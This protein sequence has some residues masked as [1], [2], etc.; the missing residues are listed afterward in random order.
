MRPLL[1]L[2]GFVLMLPDTSAQAAAAA[3]AAGSS[4]GLIQLSIEQLGQIE[5]TSVSRREESLSEAPA[6]IY[7]IT[8]QQI[9]LSGVTSIPEALRL[10]PGVEVARNGSHSW[11]ISLRGFNSDL[12]NK[13]LVL[14]D[15]RT[16][17]SPLFA[18]V[19]WDVQ[20]MLL[21]DIERIEVIA[22]PGGTL[23]GSNA[24]NGVINIITRSAWDTRG[25]FFGSAPE[26]RTSCSPGCVTA[27][28]SAKTLPPA[29]TSSVS[30][31][32][33]AAAP[34]GTTPTT[35]GT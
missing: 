23:W 5:V 8:Q 7:V 34:V 3:T 4:N 6:S 9:R 21:E 31:G 27:G 15:G 24:V 10:A 2:A 26:T 12:S 11:T 20:D 33:T 16:V 17:Y 28:V 1:A 19:Y 25:G 29:A 35:S 13:L 14:I 22:G 18:G 30:S 32:T